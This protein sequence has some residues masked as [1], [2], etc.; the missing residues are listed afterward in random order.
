M[1]FMGA[2]RR[3]DADSLIRHMFEHVAVASS[4]EKCV[5]TPHTHTSTHTHTLRREN[6]PKRYKYCVAFMCAV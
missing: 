3:D 1:D 4:A 2:A 6:Q 5:N